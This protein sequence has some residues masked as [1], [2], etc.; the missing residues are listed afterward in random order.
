MR[1]KLLTGVIIVLIC[2]WVA[3]LGGPPLI[4]VINRHFGQFV[5]KSE[6]GAVKAN[7]WNLRNALAVYA[8]DG[9]KNYPDS[10]DS[11]L[12]TIPYLP[13]DFLPYW[14]TPYTTARHDG[15]MAV[16]YFRSFTPDD[17]GGWGYVNEPTDPNFGKV[18]VNCTHRNWEGN[19]WCDE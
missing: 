15:T 17:S 5:E 16:H 10:L 8:R 1:N 11:I 13:V 7:L 12:K 4:R 9:T 2:F 14:P 19:R 3:M 18:F 6:V